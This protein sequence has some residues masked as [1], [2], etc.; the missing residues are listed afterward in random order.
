MTKISENVSKAAHGVSITAFQCFSYQK[1]QRDIQPITRN[2]G[3][4]QTA[5][6]G[7]LEK[8]RLVWIDIPNQFPLHL[9]YASIGDFDDGDLQRI[10]GVVMGSAVYYG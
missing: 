9:C 2:L 3:A 5:Q 1:I 7:R 6:F 8:R 4:D 10:A